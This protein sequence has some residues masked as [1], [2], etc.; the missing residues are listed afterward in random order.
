VTNIRS[1]GRTPVA[2]IVHS[3]SVILVMIFA[4]PLAQDIPLAS[5]AAI[6][7]F[8]AYNM[9]E[10]KQFARMQR[11]SGNYRAILVTTFLLTIVLDLTIAVEVGLAMACLFFITRVSSL[12]RLDPIEIDFGT[13]GA[14]PDVRIESYTLVGSLFFGSVSVLETLQN[15]RRNVP[16]ITLLDLGGL[17]NLDTTGLEALENLDTLLARQGGYLILARL[18]GQPESLIQRSGF[19]AHLGPNRLIANLDQAPAII[20]THLQSKEPAPS[21]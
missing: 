6:L 1:G 5:L 18:S 10:W 8:V 7:L 9:G 11:F 21:P 19:A 2:G 14:P 20:R 13:N 16:D 12:T 17:L 4:A 3:L 15:P